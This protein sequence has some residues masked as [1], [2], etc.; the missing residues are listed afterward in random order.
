[1]QKT[2]VALVNYYNA[3]PFFFGLTKRGSEEFDVML[4]HPARCAEFFI[5][6]EVDIALLP[7]GVL[8]EVSD[9]TIISDY[10]IACDGP[11]RTVVLMSHTPIENIDTIYLDDHSRTSRWL[12]K[13]LMKF[14]YKR[15]PI[16]Y[17][18]IQRDDIKDSEGILMI[19]DKV[20][21]NEKKY[22]YIYDLGAV[23][24]EWTGLPFVFAVWIGRS[25]LSTERLKK[26][27]EYVVFGVNNIDKIISDESTPALDLSYY[28]KHHIAYKISEEAKQGLNL[29]LDKISEYQK[30]IS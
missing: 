8:P 18:H 15:Q 12:I 5:N 27:E 19:G 17:H 26:F 21:D 4:A 16:Y 20:F 7:C 14:Y 28:Y 22:A 23:W 10:G 24:K 30:S 3:K 1:M 11:V 29:F 6:G 25:T 9:Y 13:I 2:S